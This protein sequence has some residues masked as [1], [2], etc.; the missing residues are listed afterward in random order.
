MS[1]AARKRE[2]CLIGRQAKAVDNKLSTTQSLGAVHA[3]KFQAKSDLV[4]YGILAD[5]AVGVLEERCDLAGNA[6]R[7]DRGGIQPRNAHAARGGLKQACE[8]LGERG[9]AGT[10]LADDAHELA[11]IEGQVE[12]VDG[13]AAIGIGKLNMVEG[14]HGLGVLGVRAQRRCV[15]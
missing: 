3:A 2:R 5:L 14:E 7:G 12:V 11:G 8:Q 10:V 13:G 6:A 1:L 15:R 9:L 4:E